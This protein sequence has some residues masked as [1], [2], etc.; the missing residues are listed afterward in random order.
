[1]AD[2]AHDVAAGMQRKRSGL[3]LQL[4]VVHLVKQPVPLAPIAGV[5]AGNKI[6]PG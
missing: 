6:L 3:A 1:V 4:H 5:A 2:H